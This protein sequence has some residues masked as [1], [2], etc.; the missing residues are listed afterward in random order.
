MIIGFWEGEV[1]NIIKE[2]IRYI[3]CTAYTDNIGFHDNGGLIEQRMY[4]DMKS[5]SNEYSDD[6]IWKEFR[7]RY[8]ALW[9]STNHIDLR[10]ARDHKYQK[11]I[12]CGMSRKNFDGWYTTQFESIN[13]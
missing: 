13:L 5:I 9:P 3:D 8:R 2:D 6:L 1:G 4:E 11:R 12:Q 7:T 10:F